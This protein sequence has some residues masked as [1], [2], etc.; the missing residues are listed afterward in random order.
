ME[1]DSEM[2][3][4]LKEENPGVVLDI[5]MKKQ[6]EV[7]NDNL[8]RKVLVDNTVKSVQVELNRKIMESFLFF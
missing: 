5:S 8:Y 2:E 3:Q 4:N 7:K 6:Q 1:E